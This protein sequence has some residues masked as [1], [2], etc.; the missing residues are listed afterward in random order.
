MHSW[1]SL[2]QY[3]STST[4]SFLKNTRWDSRELNSRFF[5][6]VFL[7]AR[8]RVKLFAR[9][10]ALVATRRDRRA[11]WAVYLF[12]L[13]VGTWNQPLLV[14]KARR[15]NGFPL[16]R[17]ISYT[18]SIYLLINPSGSLDSCELNTDRNVYL[19]WRTGPILL[20]KAPN[21]QRTIRIYDSPIDTTHVWAVGY[22][23]LIKK[24]MKNTFSLDLFI[25]VL[26][27]Y[28]SVDQHTP[29]NYY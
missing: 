12:I 1:S 8:R 20:Y 23:T 25:K 4:L 11:Q 14:N 6:I 5:K 7:F 3:T 2:F 16:G 19:L 15:E 10:V 28:S 22:I 13:Y 26:N 9:I 21:T 29:P 18:S 24:D 17:H 27:K